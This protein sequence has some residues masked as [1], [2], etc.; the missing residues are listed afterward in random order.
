[1]PTYVYETIP[2][3]ETE[4]AQRFEVRQSMSDKPLTAHPETGVPVRRLI[5]G[6]TGLMGG[7]G[8]SS[9]PRPSG[10]CGSGCGCHN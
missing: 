10:G 1:M 3:T 2:Q 6:G 9:A 4:S 5:S 7:A 8:V